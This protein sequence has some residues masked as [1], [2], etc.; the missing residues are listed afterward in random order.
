MAAPHVAGAVANIWSLMPKAS[1]NEIIQ[2]IKDKATPNKINGP[3]KSTTNK[4]LYSLVMG[5]A[6][7]Y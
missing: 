2:L 4:L 1:N 3:I 7:K 6:K 5:D